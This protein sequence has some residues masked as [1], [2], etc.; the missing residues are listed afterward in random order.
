MARFPKS[1]TEGPIFWK[2]GS[3]T[4]GAFCQ[5]AFL[6]ILEIFRLDTDQMS[7]KL[8]EKPFATW[9]H[10]FLSTG[11]FLT[12]VQGE[13]GSGNEIAGVSFYDIF[14]RARAEIKI[15]D[16]IRDLRL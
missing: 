10:A 13:R 8:H 7:S 4:P 1:I 9:P 14:G 11:R 5:N 6:E 16:E 15:L 3:L 2:I 12:A